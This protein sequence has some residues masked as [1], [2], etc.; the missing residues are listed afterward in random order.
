MGSRRLWVA[1]VICHS[2]C[3][4]S[5]P[6]SR[7]LRMPRPT[8][9]PLHRDERRSTTWPGRFMN[10][11]KSR[12]SRWSSTLI[13]LRRT[14]PTMLLASPPEPSLRAWRRIRRENKSVCFTHAAKSTQTASC[15]HFVVVMTRASRIIRVSSRCPRTRPWGGFVDTLLALARYLRSVILWARRMTVSVTALSG[16][17]FSARRPRTFSRV[18]GVPSTANRMSYG[19]RPIA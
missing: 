11:R 19:L 12:G 15:K 4:F 1:Q 17:T 18:T 6:R 3:T 10:W 7:G 5:R 9:C 14:T 13:S 16:S 2:Q 8:H